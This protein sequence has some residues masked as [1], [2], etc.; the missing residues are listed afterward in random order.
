MQ[1]VPLWWVHMPND[2]WGTSCVASMGMRQGLPLQ[3][4]L[5]A[6]RTTD[7]GDASL[8]GVLVCAGIA[9]STLNC[10]HALLL[11]YEL[12]SD[13][14]LMMDAYFQSAFPSA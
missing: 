8:C 4:T 7:A 9:L 1:P 11:G 6:R 5:D 3:V 13:S 10:G 14:W 12:M 2:V